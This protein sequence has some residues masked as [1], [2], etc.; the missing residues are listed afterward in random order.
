MGI[1]EVQPLSEKIGIVPSEPSSPSSHTTGESDG[2]DKSKKMLSNDPPVIANNMK[3]KEKSLV[4]NQLVTDIQYNDM[5]IFVGDEVMRGDFGIQ[6]INSSLLIPLVPYAYIVHCVGPD[7]KW[8]NQDG[9]AG[10]R[11][12]VVEVGVGADKK[13]VRVEWLSGGCSEYRWGSQGG[14][15]DLKRIESVTSPS[16]KTIRVGDTVVRGTSVTLYITS[17]Y[18]ALYYFTFNCTILQYTMLYYILNYQLRCDL[19]LHIIFLCD[20]EVFPSRRMIRIPYIIVRSIFCH[21]VY[22]VMNIHNMPY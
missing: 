21:L 20:Y 14:K 16:G 19:T 7:W 13:W 1:Y 15:Y 5:S 3:L 4:M 12:R 10:G 18:I 11:G 6:Y 22:Q 2:S 8:Y 9:G 17:F